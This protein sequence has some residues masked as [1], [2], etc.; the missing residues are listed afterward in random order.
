MDP[1]VNILNPGYTSGTTLRLLDRG[2]SDFDFWCLA[3]AGVSEER[4][5]GALDSGLRPYDF[6]DARKAGYSLDDYLELKR[7][8]DS[9]VAAATDSGMTLYLAMTAG[10]RPAELEGD[11]V[12]RFREDRHKFNTTVQEEMGGSPEQAGF[13]CLQIPAGRHLG[14]CNGVV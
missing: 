9:F 8:V 2:L 1:L 10:I 7:K 4:V 5:F 12:E 14:Q 13:S 3:Q 11:S 6:N